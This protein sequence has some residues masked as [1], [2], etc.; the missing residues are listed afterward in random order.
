MSVSLAGVLATTGFTSRSPLS[1]FYS[2]MIYLLSHAAAVL[3]CTL[4]T[5]T[6]THAHFPLKP[7]SR[8]PG[9]HLTDLRWPH[10]WG[11]LAPFSKNSGERFKKH[12]IDHRF[13]GHFRIFFLC[14]WS[15]ERQFLGFFKRSPL[16]NPPQA[17]PLLS[18]M[19]YL[20]R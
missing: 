18:C 11:R 19:I 17:S 4:H 12:K 15:F 10:R 20:Q 5:H 2:S 13:G 7:G 16:K 6:H 3:A 9:E 1:L 8:P 14:R